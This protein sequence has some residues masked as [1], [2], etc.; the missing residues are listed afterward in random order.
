MPRGRLRW[1]PGRLPVPLMGA[2]LASCVLPARP[3]VTVVGEPYVAEIVLGSVRRPVNRRVLGSN[4]QW[5]DRG[6]RLLRAGTLEFEPRAFELAT[7]LAPT[8]LRYPGGSQGDTYRWAEGVGPVASRG[9]VELF[10]ARGVW[11]RVEF[12]TAEFL[13]FAAAVGAEPLVTVNATT[14]S[15]AEAAAWVRAVNRDGVTQASGARLAPGSPGAP[16]VRYWEI[17]NEPY[18]RQ[19]A[20]PEFYIDASEFARRANAFI[21]AMRAVD[22]SLVI[23]LPIRND[24]VG[25]L[26]LEQQTPGFA[27]RVLREVTE[28][29]DYVA[30]H[31]AYF[32][33][34]WR[35]GVSPSDAELFRAL[36]GAALVVERDFAT[37]RALLARHQPGRRVQLA[38]T[39]YNALFSIGGPR[40][41]YMA[42]LGGAL[43]VAELLRLFAETDDLLLAAHWSLSDNWYFGSFSAQ[44]PRSSV[45]EPRPAYHVLEAFG[46]VLRGYLLAVHVATP[47]YSTA[48]LGL[49]TAEDAVPALSAVATSE[50]GRVRVLLLNKDPERPAQLTLRT[51]SGATQ[52]LVTHRQLADSMLFD[53][54]GARRT[55]Q[56]RD[57]PITTQGMPLPLTIPPHS[58]TWLELTRR[59]GA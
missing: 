49:V 15:A 26:M 52:Q 31:N 37:T 57:V 19:D 33:F 14:G 30:L 13:A 55:I 28:P 6:D 32:P 22:P 35:P 53:Q 10:Y 9:E 4:V 27:A 54:T 45:P 42:T 16:R 58:L 36:M 2:I 5:L 18:L 56:W 43:Y 46:A 44:L 11:Q 48:A 59:G 41:G 47:T 1:S 7:R 40:D 17:D 39:E 20:R 21:S 3:E 24:T 12:G 51:A 29:F 25:L 34:L 23:G 8:V 50:D 38:V